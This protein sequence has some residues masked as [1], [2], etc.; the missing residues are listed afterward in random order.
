M[1]S[2]KSPRLDLP[3]RPQAA[4]PLASAPE[5]SAASIWNLGAPWTLCFQSIFQPVTILNGSSMIKPYA[6]YFVLCACVVLTAM[7]EAR[8]GEFHANQ[9]IAGDGHHID[10]DGLLFHGNYCGPGSR[11]GAR[12]VDA[13]DA[14]C[15]RHDACGRFNALPSCAC[16]ARLQYEAAAIARNPA[17]RP[18]IQFL[19]SITAAVA[20]LLLCQPP[21]QVSRDPI[22]FPVIGSYRPNG[23]QEWNRGPRHH[24]LTH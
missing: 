6:M 3:E 21:S 20:G 18:D 11:P 5:A 8:S 9:S 16:N 13:L 1:N 10:H 24:H 14:A 23:Y 15:M 19:A 2:P 17:Q 12:P 22:V 7:T 4:L